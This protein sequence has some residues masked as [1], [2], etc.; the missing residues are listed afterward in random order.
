VELKPAI[1]P[2]CGGDLRIPEDRTVVKC[3]YCGKDIIVREA[4]AKAIGPTIENYLTL[5]RS[6]KNSKNNKEA[7][8]YYTKVLE[9]DPKNHE[10]WFGKGEAAGWLSTLA[11]FRLPEM[12]TGIQNAVNF[13]P[14]DEKEEIQIK[15]ARMINEIT[16]AYYNLSLNH[17]FEFGRL[18]AARE[19]FMGRCL[20]MIEALEIA[21]SIALGEKVIIDNI[22]HI[23]K[24]QI[25]G[26]HYMDFNEYGEIRGTFWAASERESLLRLKINEYVE[27]RKS[28]EPSYQPPTIQRKSGCFI[29]TATMGNFNHPYVILLREF[30]DRWLTK[31]TLGQI[32]VEKYYH[33]SPFFAN[34]IRKRKKLRWISYAF[35]VEP[36]VWLAT[37]LLRKKLKE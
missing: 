10:A 30:R 6:A 18:R 8:D 35:V 19:E 16:I 28:L 33:Y 11:D 15:G 36:S 21:H 22:I 37:E 23:C 4:I 5:A 9:L 26:I 25:E 27:K 14:S 3:M 32:F 1:C 17:V 7:Y 34:V 13:S 12:V 2:N 29:V 24:M 31:K 20:R